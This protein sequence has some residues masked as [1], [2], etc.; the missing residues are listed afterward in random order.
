MTA[1]TA[2][3]A[4]GATCPTTIH[5]R[6]GA[7]WR[8]VAAIDRPARARLAH[9]AVTK[10]VLVGPGGVAAAF[11]HN[12]RA[13]VRPTTIHPR[14]GAVLHAVGAALTALTRRVTNVGGAVARQHARRALTAGR[15]KRPAAVHI[16][17]LA[18]A[19]PVAAAGRRA[20]PCHLADAAFAIHPKLTAAALGTARAVWTAAVH[21]RLALVAPPIRA[22]RGSAYPLGANAA[23]AVRARRAAFAAGARTTRAAAVHIRLIEVLRPIAADHI[24]AGRKR[25]GHFHL[26]AAAPNHQK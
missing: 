7:V 12:T 22:A 25:V 23:L 24:R 17:L 4:A 10:T 8:P 15:T 13:A 6:L 2:A 26:A 5:P 16:R 20:H 21:V 1:A 14:L 19:H 9:A 3:F 11:A 18:V